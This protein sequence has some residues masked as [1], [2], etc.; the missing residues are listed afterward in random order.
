MPE[1]M[2]RFKTLTLL[3]PR[4]GETIDGYTIIEP[5]G[6]GACIETYLAKKDQ[7]LVALKFLKREYISN[8]N[9]WDLLDMEADVLTA[10][11]HP[12]LPLHFGRGSYHG[13]P[14]LIQQYIPGQTLD[15]YRTRMS[16][17]GYCPELFVARAMISVCESLMALEKYGIVHRDVKP[18]NIIISGTHGKRAV[19]LIDF[20]AAQ[21]RGRTSGRGERVGI[22]VGTPIYLAPEVARGEPATSLSDI[23]SVGAT[24]YTLCFHAWGPYQLDPKSCVTTENRKQI[25]SGNVHLPFTAFPGDHALHDI[26]VRATQPDPEKRFPSLISLR[27]ALLPLTVKTRKT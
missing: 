2:E 21:F 17:D 8:W 25:M 16:E 27:D 3:G 20:G 26:V 11:E 5:L 13:A 12:R 14:Y 10:V 15:I 24:I 18:H 7:N 1:P 22:R 4:P 19:T 23:F 6:S 9:A